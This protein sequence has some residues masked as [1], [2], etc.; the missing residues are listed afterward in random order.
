MGGIPQ[1]LEALL[2]SA[3]PAQLTALLQN[4]QGMNFSPFNLPP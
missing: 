3:E 1:P 2:S 4:M